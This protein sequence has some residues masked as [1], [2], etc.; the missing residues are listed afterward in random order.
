[1]M[2]LAYLYFLLDNYFQLAKGDLMLSLTLLGT[3]ILGLDRCTGLICLGR[4]IT[5]P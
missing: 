3:M 2:P 1:M 5:C 4:L